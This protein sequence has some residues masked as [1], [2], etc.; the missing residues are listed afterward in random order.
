ML[1]R[2][3]GLEIVAIHPNS[4]RIL[5]RFHETPATL[6]LQKGIGRAP[7]SWNDPAE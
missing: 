7:G 3:L 1:D 2:N 6:A 4:A 5:H